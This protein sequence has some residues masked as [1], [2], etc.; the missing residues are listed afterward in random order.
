MNT[1]VGLFKLTLYIL[2]YYHK[3]IITLPEYLLP[4]VINV[5][6]HKFQ[7]CQIVFRPCLMHV[8][9]QI[10]TRVYVCVCVHTTVCVRVKRV[11]RISGRFD[12]WLLH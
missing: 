8:Y 9:L 2:C 3:Y 12:L 7:S 1:A 10:L 5:D 4:C 11:N 6:R